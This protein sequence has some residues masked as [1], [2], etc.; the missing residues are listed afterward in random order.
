M[1]RLRETIRRQS[2]NTT[3][4]TAATGSQDIRQTVRD[5]I[6]DELDSVSLNLQL[7]AEDVTSRHSLL[8][9]EVR[10]KGTRPHS[11]DHQEEPESER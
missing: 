8:E 11:Q 9:Q 10:E 7:F 6:H 2:T 3:G 1:A 4:M 5:L